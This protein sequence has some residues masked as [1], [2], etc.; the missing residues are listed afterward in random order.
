MNFSA[1][2]TCAL[3]P[4]EEEKFLITGRGKAVVADAL[5]PAEAVM[6][7]YSGL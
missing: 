6:V 3:A 5:V 4:F 1:S 2:I 7:M